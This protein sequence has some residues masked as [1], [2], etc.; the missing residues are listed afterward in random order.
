MTATTYRTEM[1]H[2]FTL[3]NQITGTTAMPTT[4]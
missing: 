3:W 2:R 4:A 1:H